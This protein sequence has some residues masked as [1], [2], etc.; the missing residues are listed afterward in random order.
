[1][2]SGGMGRH[3]KQRVLTPFLSLLHLWDAADPFDA[4]GLLLVLL[5][6][7]ENRR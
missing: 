3:V 7:K 2:D 6:N 4:A 5:K 1:M